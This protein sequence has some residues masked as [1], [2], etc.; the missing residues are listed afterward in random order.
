MK[1]FIPLLA[2][3]AANSSV[4]VD[5]IAH[6]G[7]ACGFSENSVAA[8]N[9]AWELGS[10]G[11]E[12][13]VR[14]SIDG[15]PF[16]YH[17]EKLGNASIAS[18]PYPEIVEKLGDAAPTLEQALTSAPPNGHYILDL[19]QSGEEDSRSVAELL[20]RLKTNPSQIVIQSE[21][22]ASLAT[23]GSIFVGVKLMYLVRLKRKGVFERS[24]EP[25]DVLAQI[26]GR[27]IHGV[28]LKGRSYLDEAYVGS[29][30]EEGYRV[31]VWTINRESRAV[32]YKKIGVDGIITDRV[33]R[34]QGV[35]SDGP[36]VEE[37]CDEHAA[38]AS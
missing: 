17:D 8:I 36:L 16:L 10:D 9:S 32:Y 27:S 29:I 23:V 37:T 1:R 2:L 3:L 18:L 14:V 34:I 20:N 30:K 38:S 11:V 24:P 22:A 19:K 12:I 4:A 33:V 13:D 31:Y 25:E 26:R 7:N 15:I 5:V 28:S 6:R 21:N 35:V